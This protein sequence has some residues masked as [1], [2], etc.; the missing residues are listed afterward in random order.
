VRHRVRE[1]EEKTARLVAF[2]EVDR[3]GGV[4]L[5]HV[6]LHQR[7]FD[8]PV[9][10]EQLHRAHVVRIG[11]AKVFVETAMC[12]EPLRPGVAEVPFADHAG[13]VAGA[14]E[15]LGEGDFAFG[16]VEVVFR[17]PLA[18]GRRIF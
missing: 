6:G 3:P 1:V 17:A 10:L 16:Q 13:G 2:D 9:A 5:G 8:A 4:A 14:L 11:N 18:I 7:I 12:R 15:E